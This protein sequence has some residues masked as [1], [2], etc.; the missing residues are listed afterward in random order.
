MSNNARFFIP[1]KLYEFKGWRNFGIDTTFSVTYSDGR[2]REMR[3]DIPFVVLWCETDRYGWMSFQ[4][5]TPEGELASVT[6]FELSQLHR[7][8][9]EVS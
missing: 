9:R 2:Y 7:Y 1:G 4:I 3:Q 6:G 5:L 8:F